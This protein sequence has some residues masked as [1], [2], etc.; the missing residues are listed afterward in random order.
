M[1]NF[2]YVQRFL[3]NIYCMFYEIFRFIEN[4]AKKFHAKKFHA[5]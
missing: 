5:R 2:I 1:S 3:W 4:I